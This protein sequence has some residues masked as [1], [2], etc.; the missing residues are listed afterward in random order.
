MKNISQQGIR[1]LLFPIPS[2]E[3]QQRIVTALDV[4]GRRIEEEQRFLKKLRTL[5]HGLMGDLLT[6]RVRVGLPKEVS[7]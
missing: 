6:G 5:K 2:V 1:G 3:E 7:A 4:Q